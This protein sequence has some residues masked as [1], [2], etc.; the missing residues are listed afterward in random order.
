MLLPL[1]HRAVTRERT[2]LTF[3]RAPTVAPGGGVD[4]AQLAALALAFN[5]RLRSGLGDPTK[6]IAF[7]IAAAF[8]QM[9]NP[10]S[11]G[12][13]WPA[14]HE[15]FTAYQMRP[16]TD[17]EWPATWPGL[18]EG[19]NVTNPIAAW[20]W[21][22]E[23][24]AAETEST[25]LG[26]MP[27]SLDGQAP[28]SEED[29]FL[30]GVAQRGAI[31]PVSGA[32]GCPAWDAARSWSRI[33]YGRSSP[34]GNAYG[35]W[36]PAP[37][38]Q[39]DDCYDPDPTDLVPAPPNYKIE[40]TRL[41][42]SAS[43]DAFHHASTRTDDDGRLVLT[44]A[45]T[46][47]AVDTDGDGVVDY[48]DHIAGI[49]YSPWGYV[50]LLNSGAVDVLP[51]AE[52]MEGPY[53][54]VPR[55]SKVP[56]D[57]LPRLMNAF[58]REFRGD[59]QQVLAAENLAGRTERPVRWNDAAFNVRQ[60]QGRQYL[61]APAR[62]R[63]VGEDVL[64]EYPRFAWRSTGAACVI[65]AGTVATLE[66]GDQSGDG[67]A[68]HEGFVLAGGL[69]AASGLRTTARVEFLVDGVVVATETLSPSDG[70]AA[71]LR[72]WASPMTS[73]QRLTLRLGSAATFDQADGFIGFRLA[74]LFAYRPDVSDLWLCLRVAGALLG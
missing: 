30:L 12:F 40:F 63:L 58:A 18:P 2:G 14:Q 23:A 60:F 51:T 6:R 15:F 52:W 61:L 31:D 64:P 49:G 19:A 4:S 35:G 38:F 28:E 54:G 68:A 50:V 56:G 16:E 70:A 13:L 71:V 53:T 44:Y 66:L 17:G 72:W 24:M 67:Y 45:G 48:Q 41:A 46:C 22:N 62:G 25:R 42:A 7:Y 27:W 57:H 59:V 21:G 55:L 47:W 34:H 10:D 36:I 39:P 20:I 11:S 37:Q 74:E 1:A 9:R 43:A 33:R 3:Q 65:P 26:A 69:L 8:R 29:L 73:G 5:D 32:V